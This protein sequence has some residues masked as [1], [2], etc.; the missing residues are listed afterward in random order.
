MDGFT[1]AFGVA[2]DSSRRL[3]ITS[4]TSTGSASMTTAWTMACVTECRCRKSLQPT[5]WQIRV[6]GQIDEATVTA[7][8]W[9][10]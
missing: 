8:T 1:V 2:D 5:G 6:A 10:G 9:L 4:I 3:L 7:L